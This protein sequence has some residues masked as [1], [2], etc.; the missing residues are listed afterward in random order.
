MFSDHAPLHIRLKSENYL[1]STAGG[2]FCENQMTRQFIWDRDLQSQ[3]REVL[4]E[5]SEELMS[6]IKKKPFGFRRI[7][8]GN[9][10]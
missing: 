5:H 8:Y 7:R 10:H 1:N 6:C 2:A 4:L 9:H 3:A